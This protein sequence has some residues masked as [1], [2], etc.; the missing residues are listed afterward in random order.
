[1]RT[2]IFTLLLALLPAFAQSAEERHD[3]QTHSLEEL[4]SLDEPMYN[5]FIERYV[6]DELR[7]LRVDMND[8]HVEVTK[9][10]TNRE[11]EATTLAV[12]YASDTVTYFFYLIAGVSS[13]L[14][15][16]GWNSIRDIKEKVH[17]LADT[18]VNQVITEYE[19]RLEHLEEELNRKSRGI[20]SAQKRISQ[21]Q[22]IHSLWLKA[23][24]ESILSNR[25]AIYDQI[26]ELDPEN[27]EA[28]TYK[29]DVALE[30]N[31]P[32][33]ALNLC[34]QALRIDGDNKHAFYQMAGAY[35]LLSKPSDA[36]EYLKKA[37]EDSE[38][39]K[40]QVKND[41]VFDSLHEHEEFQ[42]LIEMK[43]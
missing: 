8:L 18:K 25:M 32:Q 42:A 40:D 6:I 34:N 13:I 27:T 26:L 1:M 37:L 33:W 29:A 5:P 19:Q 31:E 3:K 17:S 14:V 7:Q 16:V 38:G 24:Q 12:T 43:E 36:I 10:V 23:G 9:E 2:L 30:M 28:L 21:H 4:N 39:Y 20:T 22:D 11:L 35:A 15:L 41:P